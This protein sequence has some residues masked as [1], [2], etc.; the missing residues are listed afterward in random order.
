MNVGHEIKIESRCCEARENT[1]PSRRNHL[2]DLRPRS[3]RPGDTAGIS[4]EWERNMDTRLLRLPGGAF[5]CRFWRLRVSPDCSRPAEKFDADEPLRKAWS[6]IMLASAVRWVGLVLA[7]W[8]TFLP[9]LILAF[10]SL[11]LGILRLQPHSGSLGCSSAPFTCCCSLSAWGWSCGY[12]KG[13]ESWPGSS[14][15]TT[16]CWRL[17]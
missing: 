1:V 10:I 14:Q 17:F 3:Y 6:L 15:L 5:L 12:T 9:I 11:S 16:S 7:N 2:G 4:T 8:S 13:W